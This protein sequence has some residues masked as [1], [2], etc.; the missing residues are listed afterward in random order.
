MS[1]TLRAENFKA[2]RR[3]SWSP[4]GVC[5]LVGP[6]GT[7]KST[8]LKLV[9]GLRLGFEHGF[10]VGLQQFGTGPLRH[11]EAAKE[12]LCAVSL[13]VDGL[14]WT[15]L[16]ERTSRIH[17]RVGRDGTDL[18]VRAAGDDSIRT[19]DGSTYLAEDQMALKRASNADEKTAGQIEPLVRFVRG[20]RYHGR[21]RLDALR[22]SGSPQ[23]PEEAQLNADGT[24][25]FGV[26]RVWH[27]RSAHEHRWEFV[28]KRLAALF[29]RT[30]R[31]FDFEAVAQRV[32]AFVV[33]PSWSHSLTPTDWSD[34][35]FT[36]L[37]HLAALASAN[38]GGLVAIDEPETSLHPALI[39]DLLVA[40]RDWSAERDVTVLLA[41]HSPVLLDQ[42]RG[43]PDQVYVMQ[44]DGAG[45]LPAALDRLKKREWLDHYSL[46]DLYASEEVGSA[47]RGGR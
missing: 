12:E 40:M 2:L 25:L 30:F 4:A 10:V 45:E 46:G 15:L 43:E 28:T 13:E 1:F 32:S 6:N 31:R 27:D 18:V 23:S 22:G 9:E 3:F 19:G 47:Q 34:G 33:H 42:F 20:A 37:L 35:F 26:L 39:R 21:Y 29:P 5:A 41:T 8:A 7:G 44:D 11:E 14:R 16:P 17:E 36:T 38:E 24:N